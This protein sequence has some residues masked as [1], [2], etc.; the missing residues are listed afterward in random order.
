[1]FQHFGTLVLCAI[2]ALS[3]C[4]P[5]PASM[6]ASQDFQKTPI[7]LQASN[8]LPNDVAMGSNY[9]VKATVMS[10]GFVNTYD[11]DTSYGPLRVESTALLM[12][13]VGELK[14]IS[15]MEQLKGTDVYMNAA[16][17]VAAGPLQTA[18]G[19]VQDPGGTLSG[20]ASGIGRFFSNVSSAATSDSPY[21][22]SLVNSALGQASYK[23]AYAFEFGVDPYSSYE[24]LQKALNDVAWTAAVGGLTV[25]AAF[26]AIPGGAGLVVGMTSSAQTLTALVR[27]KTPAELVQLNQGS[28]SSMGVPDPTAQAFILNPVFDPQEQTLLVGALAN[29]PGVQNR[30]IFIAKAGGVTDESVALFL[31]TRAQLMEQYNLKTNSAQRFVDANGIPVLQT[32]NGR[33]IAI[34]PLDYIAWTAAFAQKEAAVSA[35][36]KQ[37]PGVTGKE[38]WITGKVDSAAR[39]ALEARGWKVEEKIRDRLL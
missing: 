28:L 18:Q 10:D 8:V 17:Q 39:R 27:D 21:Q 23:R 13:R 22:G 31:R 33:I 16:R 29:M 5:V 6:A 30:S 11:L 24:P 19:L 36:L 12:K 25:K 38:L 7:V 2:A 15:R 20:V 4:V 1:M 32:S 3:L 37:T 35:A 9:M 34:F 26:M 14:A